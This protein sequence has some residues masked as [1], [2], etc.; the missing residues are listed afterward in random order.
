[1]SL[2]WACDEEG[3]QL[4]HWNG[5]VSRRENSRAISMGMCQG[6]TMVMSLAWVEEGERLSSVW[7]CVEEGEQL[8]HWHVSRGTMAVSLA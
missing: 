5:H 4:C 2:V 7:A 3:E 6:G 8:C 1:M